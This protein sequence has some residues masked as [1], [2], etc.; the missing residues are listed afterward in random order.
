MSTG[1]TNA[2]KETSVNNPLGRKILIMRGV[3]TLV[4][5]SVKPEMEKFLNK[6]SFRGKTVWLS[7]SKLVSKNR[8]SGL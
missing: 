5:V 6:S 8:S 1:I 4:R 7:T 3:G 2:M